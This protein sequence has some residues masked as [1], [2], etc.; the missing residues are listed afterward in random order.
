MENVYI[1]EMFVVNNKVNK[2]TFDIRVFS[3][4]KQARYFIEKWSQNKENIDDEIKYFD[5]VEAKEERITDNIIRF[6]HFDEHG[7]LKGWTE[8]AI[9]ETVLN[10]FRGS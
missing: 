3:T 7:T 5:A 2:Y 8:L 4:L 9:V 6:S 1:V 10:D